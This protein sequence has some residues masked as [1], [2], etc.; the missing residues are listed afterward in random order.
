VAAYVREVLE[1]VVEN[2][3]TLNE[4]SSADSYSL[5]GD[6][7]DQSYLMECRA[8]QSQRLI[9]VLLPPAVASPTHQ[10]DAFDERPS[11]ECGRG[12]PVA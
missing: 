10:F 11:H 3:K 9:L 2:E 8:K 5:R 4:I 1:L 12:V 7:Q 6:G